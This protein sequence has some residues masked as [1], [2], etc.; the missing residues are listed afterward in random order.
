MKQEKMSRTED[1]RE[2]RRYHD[3]HLKPLEQHFESLRLKT[4]QAGAFMVLYFN[5]PYGTQEHGTQELI[6][7]WVLS[8]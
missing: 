4:V 8:L 5:L 7:S 6:R 1:D 2:F 3:H